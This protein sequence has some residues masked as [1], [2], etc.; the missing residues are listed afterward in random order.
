MRGRELQV[1]SFYR[2]PVSYL[3][4]TTKK[5]INGVEEEVFLADNGKYIRYVCVCVY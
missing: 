2:P 5:I 4:R 1:C 3:N